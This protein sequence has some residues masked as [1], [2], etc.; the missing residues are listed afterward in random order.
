MGLAATGLAGEKDARAGPEE[1][2]RLVLGHV[3]CPRPRSRRQ[4]LCLQAQS[5]KSHSRTLGVIPAKA[6]I[7]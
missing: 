3:S 5:Y 6:G 2:K 7:Q 4:G 1:G